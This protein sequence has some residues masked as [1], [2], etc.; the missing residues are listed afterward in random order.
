MNESIF[1]VILPLLIL[2]FVAHRGYYINKHSRPEDDTMKKRE[3]GIASKIASVLGMIGLIATITFV[4]NPN[5]LAWASLPVP[6]WLRWIGVAI[7][8][9]GFALLQW[10]QI[11]L[12]KSWSDKP[13]MMTEQALITDGPYRIIRHPIYTAFIFILGSTLFISANWLIGLSW[14]GMT[15]LEIISRIRF[16]EGLMLEYFGDQYREY[17]QKTGKLFPK[18]L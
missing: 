1:R 12:G 3:E 8:L 2:A 17:M 9:T 4:I 11:T 7:A 5:W 13:R 14:I 18:V 10:A 15:V 16:E 6:A